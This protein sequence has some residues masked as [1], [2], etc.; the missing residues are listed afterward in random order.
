MY[1]FMPVVSNNTLTILLILCKQKKHLW[2]IFEGETVIETQPPVLRIFSESM[3]YPKV[4]FLKSI[5]E[6]DNICQ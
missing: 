3:F 2:G 4:F 1:S 6:A 5:K